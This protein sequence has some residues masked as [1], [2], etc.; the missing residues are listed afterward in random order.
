M[1]NFDEASERIGTACIKWDFRKEEFGSD[2][3]LPF[4]I[5]DSDFQPCPAVVKALTERVNKSVLGYSDLDEAYYSAVKGWFLYRHGWEIEDSWITSVSGIIPAVNA[6]VASLL[7]PGDKIVTQTPVYDPFESV[8]KA[9]HCVS[10]H[11]ELIRGADGRYTMDLEDLELHFREGASMLILCSPHNP[12]GRVWTE[13]ELAAVLG[14]CRRYDVI[15]FSDEIHWDLIMP[16][17][18]HVSIGTLITPDDKVIVGTAPSKT[19]NIAG[20]QASN[21]II[22]N[23][24][25]RE[26][27]QGWLF[28]RYLF[29]ANVLGLTACTA[30]YTEGA[31]WVDEQNAYLAENARAVTEFINKELPRCVV[32]P[33]EGTYLMWLDLTYLG[34]SSDELIASIISHGAGLNAGRHYGE[35]GEGFVRL[36]IAC[37]RAQLVRGLESIKAAVLELE[38]EAR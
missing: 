19:F 4:S 3:V 28:S 6:A 13:E 16:G 35:S 33:L 10:V 20:L 7:K 32:S 34:K 8:I 27:Y 38:G 15:L 2:D 5:A 12:V 25:L 17:F 18:D 1:F 11:N 36:N 21:I 30:A 24:S 37:P 14:L 31:A 26:A 9:N 22:P 29:G 23:S